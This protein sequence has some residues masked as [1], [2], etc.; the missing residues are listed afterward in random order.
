MTNSMQCDARRYLLLFSPKGRERV[1]RGENSVGP[2]F[3]ELYEGTAA[4]GS[5]PTYVAD[6]EGGGST[7]YRYP[8]PTGCSQ[9]TLAH[10]AHTVESGSRLTVRNTAATLSC[11]F[12]DAPTVQT[13]TT[14]SANV[15]PAGIK[16]KLRHQTVADTDLC[17]HGVGNYEATLSFSGKYC[18]ASAFRDDLKPLAT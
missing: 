4:P 7:G 12:P 9:P 5:T 10:V 2:A 15:P 17:E 1:V 8:P 11:T 14:M 3:A 6:A 16:Q 13:W 18:K